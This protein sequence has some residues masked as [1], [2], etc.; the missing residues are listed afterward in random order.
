MSE[1]DRDRNVHW[2]YSINGRQD[3]PAMFSRL[4]Q[5]ARNRTLSSD[6][7]VRKGTT[8]EW[9]RA[10]TVEE[11][12]SRMKK[13]APKIGAE[14]VA[15]APENDGPSRL[16]D[17]RYS[18]GATVSTAIESVRDRLGRIRTLAGYSLFI[19]T[20]F[21]LAKTTLNRKM[22]DWSSPAD[23]LTTY[24]AVWSELQ[25]NRSKK[26]EESVWIAFTER[27]NT[28]LGPIVERLEKEAGSTNRPAQFL[29][30]AGRDCLPKML[31]DARDVPSSSEQ[32]FS[33]Y[34][35][36]VKLL[37]EGKPIYGGNQGG[38]RPRG[39]GVASLGD[40]F[41]SDPFT[42]AITI[43]LTVT[44]VGLVLWF[45]RSRKS[46]GASGSSANSDTTAE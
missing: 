24:Q 35:E 45:V 33:E 18:V 32:Q 17:L 7:L 11:L 19:V 40:W 13:S 44:N 42:G 8:G 34:L 22:F 9:V 3:G 29:L 21:F 25:S 27:S 31:V 46:R 12:R 38:R 5:M 36:N 4:R 30:W 6:D 20:L 10:D 15:T 2:Y 23:P 43:L 16:Q 37:G 26:V 28:A 14:P 41:A 1:A 39:Q